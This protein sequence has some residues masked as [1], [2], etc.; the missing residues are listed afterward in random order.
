VS[1]A[2]PGGTSPFAGGFPS[3]QASQAL[4][5]AAPKVCHE[6]GTLLAQAGHVL[7]DAEAIIPA[8][9]SLLLA[10]GTSDKLCSKLIG[11]LGA[12]RSALGSVVGWLEEAA[13]VQ[14]TIDQHFLG[15]GAKLAAAASIKTRVAEFPAPLAG[16]Q[17]TG[18]LAAAVRSAGAAPS[19]AASSAGGGCAATA[20]AAAA[21]AAVVAAGPMAKA[22]DVAGAAADPPPASKLAQAM[23]GMS[24][25][26]IP[27]TP[28]VALP[29]PPF[30]V[31]G[32]AKA[33]PVRP[34]PGAVP[35]TTGGP[36]AMVPPPPGDGGAQPLASALP[37]P[38][39][40]KLRH[41]KTC[42][43]RE[44]ADWRGQ[45]LW[46]RC[47]MPSEVAESWMAESG[48]KWHDTWWELEDFS[49]LAASFRAL[50]A[51]TGLARIIYDA[52]VRSKATRLKG[53]LNVADVVTEA[54]RKAKGLTPFDVFAAGAGSMGLPRDIAYAQV[55]IPGKKGGTFSTTIFVRASVSFGHDQPDSGAAA[56]GA[57]LAAGSSDTWGSWTAGP[58]DS[59]VW[60]PP[61]GSFSN[62]N[63]AWSSQVGSWADSWGA[64]GT[65]GAAGSASSW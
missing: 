24:D 17:L 34:S 32:G 40:G 62:D 56:G 43:A 8:F 61:A 46:T 57:G 36:S 38:R 3:W 30:N 19:V 25:G 23:A 16:L 31:F 4:I 35:N 5:A 60:E 2:G 28:A 52:V 63:V 55:I 6:V 50:V 64:S 49:R 15:L 41:T 44:G 9:K 42:Y 59:G 11:E 45:V 47:D 21:R 54:G 1:P 29:R 10:K 65:A 39:V 22:A 13:G 51:P 14:H 27:L 26:G 53:W 12:S 37:P 48:R 58:P 33:A 18:I 20:A 7:P